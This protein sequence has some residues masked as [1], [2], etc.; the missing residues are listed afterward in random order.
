M[1]VSIT[2]T[3]KKAACIGSKIID[4]VSKK[5]HINS[6]SRCFYVF[7]RFPCR[8]EGRSIRQFRR[9]VGEPMSITYTIDQDRQIIFTEILG[10]ITLQ[11]VLEHFR[12]LKTDHNVPPNLDVLLDLRQTKSIP[13]T[14]Q[15]ELIT[16]EIHHLQSKIAWRYCA[17]VASE[18]ALYGMARVL[19]V[20]AEKIFSEIQVFYT[21][22]EAIIW[23]ESKINSIVKTSL[24]D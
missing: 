23:L 7:Y 18:P 12:M 2:C 3:R 8:A 16:E 17:I 5:D 22:D 19:G 1:E 11:D 13:S 6:R 9:G 20:I 15:I 4:I 24:L 10:K 21:Y 14:Q